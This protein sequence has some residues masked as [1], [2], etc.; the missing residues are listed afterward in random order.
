[1]IG[2]RSYDPLAPPCDSRIWNGT[3]RRRF[4]FSQKGYLKFAVHPVARRFGYPGNSP[5]QCARTQSTG[6][7][8]RAGLFARPEFPGSGNQRREAVTQRRTP[9]PVGRGG[10]RLRM[11]DHI[12][13]DNRERRFVVDQHESMGYP[14][15][16]IGRTIA[17]QVT[18][19][20]THRTVRFDAIGWQI[21]Q[22]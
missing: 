3:E 12:G 7:G 18:E 10:E 2:A 22:P 15:V 1:R 5:L 16:P 8:Q 21:E 4:A 17:E 19:T 6:V 14:L 11:T 20:E 9:A 13:T